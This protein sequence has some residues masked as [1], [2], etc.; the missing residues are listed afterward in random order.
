MEVTV[1]HRL[2]NLQNYENKRTVGDLLKAIAEN[3]NYR[4][5]TDIREWKLYYLGVLLEEEDELSSLKD[6]LTMKPFIIL[7]EPPEIPRW[8]IRY[9]LIPDDRTRFVVRGTKDEFDISVIRP[10][11]HSSYDCP[12]EYYFDKKQKFGVII[13][14]HP[15]GEDRKI[16]YQIYELPSNHAGHVMLWEDPR[17][18][19]NWEPAE[20]HLITDQDNGLYEV[21]RPTTSE[22]YEERNMKGNNSPLLEI[23]D[24]ITGHSDQVEAM[25]T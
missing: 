4:C 19:E 6:D 16:E 25:D 12:R 9:P 8:G 10:C 17:P 22:I 1:L 3:P 14:V 11:E 2:K 5:H 18:S 7:V 13:N 21:L 23:L 24:A 20:L 15:E